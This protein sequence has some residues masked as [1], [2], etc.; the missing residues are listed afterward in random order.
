M[1]SWLLERQVVRVISIGQRS[2]PLRENPPSR[3]LALPAD[4]C[5]EDSTRVAWHTGGTKG[6]Q[7]GP[8]GAW[9][10]VYGGMD[11]SGP[12]PAVHG[13]VEGVPSFV[14][15]CHETWPPRRAFRGCQISQGW[16]GHDS[17]PLIAQSPGGRLSPCSLVQVLSIG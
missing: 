11:S 2:V 3:D 1:K 5:A 14:S 8:G 13:V 12:V 17:S 9:G 6:I 15:C 7:G 4:P 10:P 16:S